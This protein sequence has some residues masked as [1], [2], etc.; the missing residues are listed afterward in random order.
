[1]GQRV[2]LY[3]ATIIKQQV[4]R[5]LDFTTFA[6]PRHGISLHGDGHPVAPNGWKKREGVMLKTLEVADGRGWTLAPCHSLV[7]I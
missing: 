1:M 2:T 7:T 4:D 3:G 6:E 5:W